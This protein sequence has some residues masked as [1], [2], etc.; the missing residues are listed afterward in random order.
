MA[1][2]KM[3]EKN[4]KKVKEDS[5]A[6]KKRQAFAGAKAKKKPNKKKLTKAE[7]KAAVM[8]HAKAM[9]NKRL[10]THKRS[11]TGKVSGEQST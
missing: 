11:K 8:S 2:A 10:N 4:K 3:A 1:T 6:E 5:P 9:R 7:V